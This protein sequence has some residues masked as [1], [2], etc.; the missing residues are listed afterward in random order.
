MYI[1]DYNQAL[2]DEVLEKIKAGYHQIF[3]S[4]ATGL[5]KSIIMQMLILQQFAG[6]RVLYIAPKYSIWNNL[7]Q[8][9]AMR[10]ADCRM[11]AAFKDTETALDII[12]NYDVIFIDECHHMYSDIQG[13]SIQKAM[14]IYSNKYFFGFTATPKLKGKLASDAFEGSCIG[15]DVYDAVKQ[16]IFPKIKY[17]ILVPDTEGDIYSRDIITQ[18]QSIFEDRRK[19]GEKCLVYLT[20]IHDL[21]SYTSLLKEAYPEYD[22]MSI[23]SKKTFKDNKMAL[24]QFNAAVGNAML[25]SVDSLMEGVHLNGVH[26]VISCRHTQSLNVFLQIMGRLCKPYSKVEPLFIDVTDSVSDINFDLDEPKPKGNG[27]GQIAQR[28]LK[29]MIDVHCKEYEY[30]EFYERLKSK[31]NK[32]QTYKDFTWSTYVQL[33]KQ[34]GVSVNSIYSWLR[35]NVGSTIYDYIDHKTNSQIMYRGVNCSSYESMAVTLHKTIHDVKLVIKLNNM[36]R[37]EYVDFVLGERT[38][39]EYNQSLS[40][41]IYRDVDCYSDET[42]ARALH[43]N[44]MKV[45]NGI[46]RCGGA[47][48]YID[49]VLKQLTLKQY[50]WEKGGNKK[51]SYHGIKYNTP[52]D[53]CAQLG[54]TMKTYRAFMRTAKADSP[55]EFIDAYMRTER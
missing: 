46:K 22:V 14:A 26:C 5:G 3:Y 18:I 32:I 45:H 1:S 23:H 49:N 40:I 20:D 36:T 6:K 42:I 24:D 35:R 10:C 2:Y 30:V 53:I 29:D 17:A 7:S 50:L 13:A 8:Y 9:E 25:L 55:R 16:G 27:T 37:Q 51:F 41:M 44:T 43:K 28:S 21:E 47:L 11:Y 31:D 54:V 33:A 39:D 19:V 38:L 4:E 48:P 34:L 12:H 15:L 52:E